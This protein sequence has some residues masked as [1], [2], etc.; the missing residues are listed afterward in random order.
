MLLAEGASSERA[1][2]HGGK[3]MVGAV[4]KGIVVVAAVLGMLAWPGSEPPAEAA[5][6]G[7]CTAA[8]WLEGDRVGPVGPRKCEAAFQG[9]SKYAFGRITYVA[10][11]RY[12][13]RITR[14]QFNHCINCL[15]GPIANWPRWRLEAMYV[16]NRQQLGFTS[17]YTNEWN[18]IRSRTESIY[19]AKR[20]TVYIDVCS[21]SNSWHG[22]T[23]GRT[24]N[25]TL[26]YT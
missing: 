1:A 2:G 19:V 18:N 4:R 16:N 17:G 10:E 15:G 11:D 12:L 9:N 20:S 5:V 23:C 21:I 7:S 25:M 13:D 6:R 24:R 22:R 26:D 14:V 8:M 3:R